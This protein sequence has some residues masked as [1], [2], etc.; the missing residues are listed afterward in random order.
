ME[1]NKPKRNRYKNENVTY[2]TV[3]IPNDLHSKLDDFKNKSGIPINKAIIL[4]TN[5]YL[6]NKAI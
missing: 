1:N 2:M 6:Q 5:L 3:R 4:A